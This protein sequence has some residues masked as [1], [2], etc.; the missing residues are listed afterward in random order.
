MKM[1][2]TIKDFIKLN[3]RGTDVLY[4]PVTQLDL[5]SKYIS[6]KDT[7][8]AIKLNKLGTDEW[9]K[10]QKRVKAAVR[11]M[12][13]ELTK[14][15]STRMNSEGYAFSP[16][17]DMQNDF[18]RRFEFEETDDQLSAIADTKA[19]M[20]STKIMDRLIC[21]DVGYGKTEIAIRAAF[22]AVSEA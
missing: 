3:Y 21:G 1:G 5:I 2:G 14:I 19:D 13:A 6:P 9:K 16:D 15:Y 17:M 12:A 10:T 7:D 8:K 20:E 22:K 4:L 18:E 11:D